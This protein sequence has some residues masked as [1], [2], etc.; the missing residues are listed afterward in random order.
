MAELRYQPTGWRHSWRYV[1]KRELAERKTG[2]LYWK[3][4]VTAT[5]NAVRSARA[6]VVWHCQ[7][8][9]MEN[10]IQ[11]HKS[12]CGLEK[13]PTQKFPANWAYLLI[14]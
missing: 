6:L 4:H 11:E 3:Y 13:L 10:A 8:A 12:G 9:T 14:G 1:V 2:E 7:H 5:N